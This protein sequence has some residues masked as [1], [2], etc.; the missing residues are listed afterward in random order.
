MSDE[1][2]ED[3]VPRESFLGWAWDL[4]FLGVLIVMALL[5]LGSAISMGIDSG[6]SLTDQVQTALWVL[7]LFTGGTFA[8][9]VL[10]SCVN[11]LVVAA[12]RNYA[13]GGLLH[14]TLSPVAKAGSMVASAISGLFAVIYSALILVIIAGLGLAILAGIAGLLL[15]GIRQLL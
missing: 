3:K 10:F 11:W 12:R 4:K 2:Q 6:A 15:F 8:V 1:D 14:T 5:I 7:A 9:V 13:T